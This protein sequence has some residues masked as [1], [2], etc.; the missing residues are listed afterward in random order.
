MRHFNNDLNILY[1]SLFQNC[2]HD[3]MLDR[4]NHRL[5]AKHKQ[6]KESNIGR[7]KGWQ[8]N[9]EEYQKQDISYNEKRV[10]DKNK[11]SN[12][13]LLNKEEYYTE[14]VDNNNGM[15]DGKYFHFE[16]KLIKNKDYNHFL[17]KKRRICDIDLEKLKFRSYG[18]GVAIFFLFLLSGIGLPV[19]RAYE[20]VKDSSFTPFKICWEFIYSTLNLETIIPKGTPVARGTAA[21]I[22]G[23]EYFYLVIFV[24]L[25]ISLG[26]LLIVA[27]PKILRNNEKYKK[28]KSMTE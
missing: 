22:P 7:P 4:R 21:P 5:L 11:Q 19:L 16:K 24:V 15:F 26:I 13:S 25:I 28:I 10:K 12:R 2:D 14:V 8:R 17:E 20:L 27:I 18:F 23:V 6:D 1:K 9:Y 3:K